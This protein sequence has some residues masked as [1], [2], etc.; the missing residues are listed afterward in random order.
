MFEKQLNINYGKYYK[1]YGIIGQ[2]ETLDKIFSIV[3]KVA[4]TQISVLIT[5]ESGTGKEVISN[6]IHKLSNRK[7]RKFIAINCGA[8]P[9]G[10]IENELFGHEKGSYTSASGQSKGYFEQADGG[11][12]FLDEV[13]ELPIQSQVKLLR[14]LETGEFFRVGGTKPISVDV[15]VVAATNKNLSKMIEE[16]S[17]REDLYFRLKAVNL[18]LPSLRERVKDIPLF[19]YKFVEDSS[20]KHSI[21]PV[22]I[23]NDAMIEI[24]AHNWKGNIRELKNFVDMLNV[25]EA[26]KRVFR[27]DVLK[28]LPIDERSNFQF[29]YPVHVKNETEFDDGNTS[30]IFKT[31]LEIKSD[32]SDIK[33]ILSR[34]GF[35]SSKDILNPTKLLTTTFV[36]EVPERA[37]TEKEEIEILLKKY[38]GN[39]RKAAQDMNI[40]ERTLY[41]KLQK[42][43]LN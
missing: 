19:V 41:R 39:R 26:G 21:P 1:D 11:T 8:I 15:R 22:F 33:M 31:L 13:G 18:R 17:F 38:N 35:D 16:K 2:S 14:V 24:V 43:G 25:M 29:S 3:K 34:G 7:N 37:E 40:S 28:Y 42:Y 10:L 30:L 9:E 36:E 23:E 32:I 20:Y 27:N 5:G 4:P 6:L 12:I